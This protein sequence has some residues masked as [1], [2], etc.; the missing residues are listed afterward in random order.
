MTNE[1]YYDLRTPYS[2]ALQIMGTRIDILDH[3]LYH[4]P[5]SGPVH[6]IQK[7]VKSKQS[8]EEKLRKLNLTDSKVNAKE[9]LLDIAGIRVICY[10]TDDIYNLVE[11]L[12]G[13]SD[14]IV[15]KEKD[16]IKH[17]KPN[18]YRSYHIIIGVPLY[19]ADATEYFPV[20]IQ[21]RTMAMDMWASLEHRIYYKKG[22]ERDEKLEEEL[23]TYAQILADLEER[24]KQHNENKI[25]HL[26]KE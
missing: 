7:R 24:F 25:V 1:Q 11:V 3:N 6:H 26:T 23:L 14:L 22:T 12:K 5:S 8:I 18:G 2:D 19:Y 15:L 4:K 13:Q 21:F 16:Y 17:P 20:E 10:F 9:H